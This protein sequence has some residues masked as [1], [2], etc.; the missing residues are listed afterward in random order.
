MKE[1]KKHLNIN[2]EFLD[3]K[4]PDRVVSKPDSPA[5]QTSSTTNSISSDRKYNLKNILIISGVV[6]FLGWIIFSDN[7]SSSS[8]SNSDNLMIGQYS[9]SHYH[10]DQAIALDP[11]E[12]E[13]QI[14]S[15]RVALE[16]RTNA[17]DSLEN[18]IDNSYV[19]DY[20]AQWEIDQYNE[21]VHE[22]NSK[23]SVYK[24]DLA[25]LDTRIDRYNTQ[26]QKHNDYLLANC[27]KEY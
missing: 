2:L 27:T 16:Y 21:L 26:S 17:L 1:P 18:Q 15:A 10:Y 25:D 6:L 23:L 22:Y 11:D 14:K 4:K 24:R 3:K 7:D 9:C 12:T 5:K 20:S 19:N 8:T 13:Q